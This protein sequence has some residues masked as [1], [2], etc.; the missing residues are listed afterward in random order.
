[1][2]YEKHDLPTQVLPA[3]LKS[4][5]ECMAFA[6]VHHITIAPS[7]LEQLTETSA[8]DAENKFPSLFDRLNLD[9]A[10]PERMLFLRDES[11]FRLAITRNRNG[12][13][14][15]KLIQVQSE[16]TEK[17]PQV[18]LSAGAKH[19]LQ[20]AVPIGAV[21]QAVSQRLESWLWLVLSTIWHNQ[22]HTYFELT[23]CRKNANPRSTYGCSRIWIHSSGLIIELQPSLTRRSA[24]GVACVQIACIDDVRR[25]TVRSSHGQ[26]HE[27]LSTSNINRVSFAMYLT[28][29][30]RQWRL[31]SM[32]HV[33]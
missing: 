10:A 32:C 18:D 33:S 12:R 11:A 14:E 16:Q 3:S 28:V 15:M 5:E 17:V 22:E 23:T 19:L 2:Y 7:L 31:S 27:T 1:M 25:G 6:G 21:L 20:H 8:V 26:A 29:V 4:I 9:R 30:L 13:N 24:S